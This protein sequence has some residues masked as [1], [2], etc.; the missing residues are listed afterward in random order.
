M[1]EQYHVSKGGADQYFKTDDEIRANLKGEAKAPWK[2]KDHITFAGDET[3]ARAL[4]R[5]PEQGIAY[6]STSPARKPGKAAVQPESREIM[7]SAHQESR[8]DSRAYPRQKA[9]EGKFRAR[10]TGEAVQ[11]ESREI[12]GYA[13]RESREGNE[14]SQAHPR[15]KAPTENF[16]ARKAG[17]PAHKDFTFPDIAA[18]PINAA[19]IH[20]HGVVD[21][22]DQAQRYQPSVLEKGFAPDAFVSDDAPPGSGFSAP[23]NAAKIHRHGIETA[24]GQI[25]AAEAQEQ[26]QESAASQN[27]GA[28][29]EGSSP[30]SDGTSPNS[31]QPEPPSRSGTY[32]NQI[33]YK[34]QSRR[35]N[36]AVPLRAAGR[37]LAA[38]VSN[39]EYENRAADV[40]GLQ[41]MTAKAELVGNLVG[42]FAASMGH[43]AVLAATAIPE[44][45]SGVMSTK[46]ALHIGKDFVVGEISHG[47]G[48]LGKKA[49]TL[50][51]EQAAAFDPGA[52]DFS[53]AAP[54]KFKNAAVGTYRGIKAIKYL[55]GMPHKKIL[56]GAGIL[57][58]LTAL[59]SVFSSLQSTSSSLIITTLCADESSDIDQLVSAINDYRDHSLTDEIYN[60][61]RSEH[62]PNG[63]PYG[64]NTLTG[65]RSNNL[66]HGVTWNYANGISNDT[67]EIISM[68][69]VYFQQNWPSSDSFSSFSG[70]DLPIF[71]FCKAVAAYGLDVTAQESHPYM[72]M[73]YG[74]C[75]QGYHSEGESVEIKDYKRV[76]HTCS[77]GDSQCGQYLGS[78]ESER[79][80]WSGGHG[81]GQSHPEWAED[82]SHTATVFFPVIFPDGA[83]QSDLTAL[84]EDGVQIGDTV[85]SENANGNLILTNS[86]LYKGVENDWFYQPGTLVGSFSVVTGEG[87]D[88]ITDAYEVTFQNATQIPWCPGC[89]NDDQHG[90]YDLNVTLYLAGYDDYSDPETSAPD[91]MSGG[92][93]N[94]TTLA[95]KLDEGSLTRTVLKKDKNGNSYTANSTATRYTKTVALPAGDAGFS[96]WFVEDEDA[97]GNV[98]WAETLYKMDWEELYGISDGIKCKTLGSSLTPEELQALLGG[99]NI[100][101]ETARGQVVAFALACQGHFT[102]GQPDSLR[103]G[104]GAAVVGT[105]LD[106]SSFIQYCYWAQ[107]LPFSAGAT[108]AYPGAG[109]LRPISAGEA[110]PGDLRV[111]YASGGVQGHVQMCLGGGSWIECCYGYGVSVNMSNA[112]MESHTCHY[113][114]YAGF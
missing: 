98:E 40:A 71:Q 102:Y 56:A 2:I 8:L 113:F 77:E 29:K 58:L 67:A 112:W 70:S 61:F 72:C 27:P 32:A 6:E 52:S 54:T 17:M 114:S 51:G 37:Q 74:G 42:D 20:R 96:H 84:P 68:A 87:E 92:S 85:S 31:S 13:H 47:A 80:E 82:G 30:P 22:H 44:I 69:A 86:N 7:G 100:D 81:E 103:G 41:P 39:E 18:M 62:D 43:G 1:P 109:D 111:V 59:L 25:D 28:E 15:Q 94:L 75:V 33:H 88:A 105:N 83:D 57:L 53:S 60:A 106:C 91:G 89:L 21:I 26:G 35:S 4:G 24:P 104:P 3:V 78:G 65:K 107:G 12:T 46:Q 16:H 38:R 95:K 64:Y 99:L 19:T 48:H 50:A 9:P 93:G 110:Q 10:E 11:S 76:T 36:R 66:T 97:D 49:L 45:R 79:W 108:A 73:P 55:A 5:K 34:R 90:H 23:L 63:N 14:D 101:P